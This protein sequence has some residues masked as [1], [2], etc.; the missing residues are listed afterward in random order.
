[1]YAID[2]SKIKEELNWTPSLQFEEGISKTIDW[3]LANQQW[4]D[5]I[6]TGKNSQS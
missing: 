3:Y 4:L 6:N 5:H 1:M 2:A